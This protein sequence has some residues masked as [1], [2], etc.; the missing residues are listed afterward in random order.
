MLIGLNGGGADKSAATAPTATVS[1]SAGAPAT[2]ETPL[3]T[4]AVDA[5]EETTAP[6]EEKQTAPAQSAPPAKTAEPLPPE[7]T[8]APATGKHP[9]AVPY[10]DWAG[11]G[12][13]RY[14]S[15]LKEPEVNGWGK[16]AWRAG[17]EC[18]TACISMAMSYLGVDASP[19]DI[20]AWSTKTVLTSS[21]GLEEVEPS[22]LTAVLIDAEKGRETL[23]AMIEAYENDETG[24]TSPVLLYLSGAGHYHALL[25]IAAEERQ[26]P[27]A[28][29]EKDG[30][31]K[32]EDAAPAQSTASP[33]PDEEQ[34]G[35]TP[36][37]ETKTE[38]VYTA[39]DPAN[40]GEHL[41]T[42]DEKG[43]LTAVEKE[44]DFLTRYAGSD[45]YP[46][47]INSLAQ[48]KL[49]TPEEE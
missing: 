41:L 2:E 32:K 47:K 43:R 12:Q 7:E 45:A 8:E 19:E 42:V 35:E 48:W 46:T 17:G 22:E 4:A 34:A 36:A 29:A 38:T 1:G 40:G 6:A 10:E 18:T 37:A 24:A 16:F 31:E 13:I 25:L 33:A 30:T 15:Q 9:D 3:P 27:A 20:L 44:D 11:K 28:A 23:T 14:V 5:G 21:Y 26:M 49:A 39:L